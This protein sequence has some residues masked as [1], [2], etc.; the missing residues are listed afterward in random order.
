MVAL[1]ATL[2]LAQPHAAFS[3]EIDLLVRDANGVPTVNAVAYAYPAAGDVSKWEP[4]PVIV[5]QIDKEFTPSVTVVPIG[6][7][8][9]FPNNDDIRH[10]VYSFSPAKT[11]ELPLY[12]GKPSKPVVFDKPGAVAL[13]CNIH[14]WMV[15]YI[16]VVDTPYYA[17]TG[18]DG[19]ARLENLQPEKY[20]VFVWHPWMRGKPEDYR[21]SATA[22][23]NTRVEFD[24]KLRAN[25][26]I[27]RAPALGGGGY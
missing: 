8:V 15:A 5:D 16:Y 1:T 7:P 11:F 9:Y 21:K 6:T 17:K 18:K 19:V 4:K 26:H 25:L 2:A 3:H 14:D 10:H 24:V 22:D 13:G 23:G 27:R 12:S 20:D